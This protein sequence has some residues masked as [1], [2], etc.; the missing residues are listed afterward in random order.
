VSN[1][2]R[3]GA[4]DPR[5]GGGWPFHYVLAAAFAVALLALV[6]VTQRPEPRAPGGSAPPSDGAARDPGEAPQATCGFAPASV[7]AT[8][9][10]AGTV[11]LGEHP[12]V[13]AVV[14]PH[15][16]HTGNPWSQWGQG[17]VL[18]DGRFVSAIGDHLGAGGD[19]YVYEFDPST[20][21]L[22]QI[23][24][25][26]SLVPRE[27]GSW[28]YGKI[29]A[30]MVAG[31]CG[32]VYLSTFYG[33]AKGLTYSGGYDGD[34]LLRLDTGTHRLTSLGTPLPRH[35]IPSLAGAPGGRLLY[36]EGPDPLSD[37]EEEGSFFVY[38]TKAG[39]VVFEDSDS[40]HVGFR[41]V[42][43]DAKGRGYFSA[44][45]RRLYVYDPGKKGLDL[46]DEKLPGKWL[47]AS[48]NPAPDGTVYG[49][50]REPD[51]LFA[52]H[53][54][55]EIDSLGKARGY[56]TSLAIDPSGRY[57]YYVPDAHGD[58][59]E[60]GTP[61]VRVD[62][63]TGKDE[64]V[65]ELNDLAEKQLGLRLGGSYN[66]VMDP[67]GKRLYVGMNAGRGNESLGEVVLMIVTL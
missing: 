9:P 30:Q 45:G 16:D 61:L 19:S 6:S 36:G 67:S 59:W 37:N 35:G 39:K 25:V 18:P 38:D 34:L 28:G 60:K 42:M 22:T 53:P 2:R 58:S 46:F 7:P 62:V 3:R 13:E 41:N 57:L 33:T 51:M 20:S 55:G 5:A 12:T 43:V 10:S 29:H 64:V 15:P 26:A 65:V 24:D 11:A 17:V 8:G 40:A 32:E 4:E 21:R 14:Y 27:P 49:A 23:A 31:A 48:T 63:A 1:P 66:V 56:V 54:S 52:L 47:R 50:T 44:G